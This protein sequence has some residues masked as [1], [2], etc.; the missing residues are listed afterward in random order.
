ML[1]T[2]YAEQFLTSI[3]PSLYREGWKNDGYMAAPETLGKLD[4]LDFFQ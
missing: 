1:S 3:Q 2:N 4:Y